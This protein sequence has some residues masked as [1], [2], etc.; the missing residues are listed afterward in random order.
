MENQTLKEIKKVRPDLS[1]YVFHFTKGRKAKEVLSSIVSDAAIID[2]GRR[3]HICFT[4]APLLSL[5]DMFEIFNQYDHPMYAPYG[6]GIRKDELYTNG[7]RPVI[8]GPKSDINLLDDS[9]HWRFETYDDDH[10]FT[11]LREWRIKTIKYKLLP[12]SCFIITNE[13]HELLF[14]THLEGDITVDAD[15]SDGGIDVSYHNEFIRQ[16]RSISIEEIKN[17]KDQHELASHINGQCLDCID[18]HM[19]LGSSWS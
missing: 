10:D 9:I 13:Y 19:Y 12:I 15:P 17:Y 3:V 14:D 5:V 8:Y 18:F 2:K 16:W 1:D 4:E 7:G 6:I 11:W